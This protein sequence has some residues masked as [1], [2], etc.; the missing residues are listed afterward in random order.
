MRTGNGQ[1]RDGD[2]SGAYWRSSP[3][4]PR[5]PPRSWPS[6]GCAPGA[7]IATAMQRATYDVL[8]T[9]ALAAEPLRAGLTPA[10]AGKAVRHLRAL[11]GAVGLTIADGERCLAF[12]GRG[13]HHG[14]QFTAAAQRALASAPLDRAH[15]RRPALRPGRLRGPRR[16]GRAARRPGRPGR[17]R[18][19]R[20]RRRPAGAGAGAGHRWR[21]PAGPARRLALAEL[22]SSRERLARAEVR[23]L[24]AQISPHF[25]YNALTAIALVRAHRPRAGPRADPRVRRVHP[26][27]VPGA[28]RVHHARRGAALDRPLPDHRTGPVRRPT[29]GTP[30]DRP[31]GAAGRPAVPVPAAAG[32][33]RRPARAVPQAGRRYGEHRSP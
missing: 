13:G 32:R 25:I 14:E 10:T 1:D 3:C 2:G 12:D 22:D 28:R 11:V 30:A 17:R 20:G 23:A 26:L 21:R 15:C 4:S 18:A 29:A 7:G 8:H 31:R 5:W 19:G 27:L 16:G 6:C 33:E 24:R 9:A